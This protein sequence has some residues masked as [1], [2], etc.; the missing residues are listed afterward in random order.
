MLAQKEK[1]L[2]GD[3]KSLMD[4]KEQPSQNRLLLLRMESLL[5]L[6]HVNNMAGAS[7]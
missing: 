7:F 4:G 3:R 6:V 2:R 1:L 5:P